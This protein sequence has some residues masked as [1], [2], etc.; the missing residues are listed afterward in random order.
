ML[1]LAVFCRFSLAR[2]VTPR[3]NFKE[4]LIAGASFFWYHIRVLCSLWHFWAGVFL[5]PVAG[6]SIH[7]H[8]HAWFATVTFRY[9]QYYNL[10]IIFIANPIECIEYGLGDIVQIRLA[11]GN[12]IVLGLG[13]FFLGHDFGI[14]IRAT[15]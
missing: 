7:P 2:R 8:H 10:G 9:R 3:N 14:S 12:L 15:M 13:L 4:A 6:P 5:L 1:G 11:W